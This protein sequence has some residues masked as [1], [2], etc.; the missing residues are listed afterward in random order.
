MYKQTFENEID[1]SYD[2]QLNITAN[3][4]SDIKP[5]K[6]PT[7]KAYSN[8]LK[9][10]HISVFVVIRRYKENIHNP[11]FDPIFRYHNDCYPIH[12]D[13]WFIIVEKFSLARD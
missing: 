10:L 13:L 1:S 11:Y 12:T 4:L 5:Y 9:N 8:T 7:R 3:Y 6:S 2:Y